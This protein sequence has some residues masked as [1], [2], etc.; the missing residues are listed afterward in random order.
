V[1]SPDARKGVPYRLDHDRPLDSMKVRGIVGS[2]FAESRFD[3]IKFDTNWVC[4]SEHD[5]Q[6]F[7]RWFKDNK[8]VIKTEIIYNDPYWFLEIKLC[9][10]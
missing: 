5:A 10:I 9:N 3:T 7:V 4:Y 6:V 8:Q 1:I 2:I